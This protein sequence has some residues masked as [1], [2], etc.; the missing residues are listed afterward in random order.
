MVPLSMHFQCTMRTKSRVA[1]ET[2][3]RLSGMVH[4]SVMIKTVF[5][6]EAS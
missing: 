6:R 1:I 3:D 2:E 5:T 4:G